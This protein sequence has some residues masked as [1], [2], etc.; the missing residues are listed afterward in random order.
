VAEAAFDNHDL[1][2]LLA[3]IDATLSAH[4]NQATAEN[5]DAVWARL[6]DLGVTELIA[7]VGQ[8]GMALPTEILVD[9]FRTASRHLAPG[10][11]LEEAFLRPWLADHGWVSQRRPGQQLALVDA[12]AT[13]DWRSSRGEIHFD[14]AGHTL[15]GAVHGV[16]QAPAATTLIVIAS[17]S[18]EP[19]AETIYVVPTAASGVAVRATAAL[20][21][22]CPIGTVTLTNAVP[23]SALAESRPEAIA[24]LRAW[25]R[26]LVAAELLGIAEAT[27]ELTR[28]HALQRTQF[29]RPIGGFQAIKHLVADMAARSVMLANLVKLTTSEMGDMPA[30]GRAVAA[31]TLKAV[32]AGTSLRIC[33]QAL[34]VHGGIGFVEEHVLHRYFKATLR[35]HGLYGTPAELYARIGASTLA[36]PA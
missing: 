12:A 19:S 3:T 23:D 1:A 35:R 13:F 10:P 22:G 8:S 18:R 24:A 2:D 6:L 29:D 21:P 5:P 36:M 34:Q 17:N 26:V 14:P 20:D 25:L 32:T 9:V 31:A 15:T 33:E 30:S 27:V 11:W 4:W 7:P 16:A 28:N